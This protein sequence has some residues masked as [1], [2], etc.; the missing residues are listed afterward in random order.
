[1]ATH[2]DVW[3]TLSKVDVSEHTEEKIGLT[4]LSWAWAWGTLKN[5]YPEAEFKFK[6]WDRPDGTKSDILEYRDGSASVECEVSIGDMKHSMWL[7]VMDNRNKSIQTP[8][9]RDISDT[10][11]RCLVKAI[12]MGFGLGFYIYAGESIPEGPDTKEDVK[13]KK[14][15]SP[16]KTEAKSSK[17]TNSKIEKTDP[18]EGTEQTEEAGVVVAYKVFAEE[19]KT[20]D[21]LK[22]FWVKNK[23]ELSKL[24]KTH[25]EIYAGVIET[26]SMKK[27]E[28][29]N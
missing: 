25:P 2:K 7:P 24:E 5:L 27:K 21:Q 6:L 13:P 22:N 15:A 18:E 11:M 8:S 20:I 3:D 23:E 1:M 16:K 10:K 9:S 14:K 17:K 29:S 28:L 19:C 4:Y 26:F 12:A